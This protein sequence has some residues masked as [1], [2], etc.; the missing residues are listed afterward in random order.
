MDDSNFIYVFKKEDMNKLL[1]LG[2]K[3]IKSDE[4]M[5][6]YVFDAKSNGNYSEKDLDSVNC[7]FTHFMTF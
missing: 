1:S 5:D 3:I 4:S 6:I 2:F 7:V